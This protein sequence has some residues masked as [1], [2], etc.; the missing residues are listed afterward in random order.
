MTFK[1]QLSA[2]A[3]VVIALTILVAACA[4]DGDDTLRVS[5]GK[6]VFTSVGCAACHGADGE[7]GFGPALAGH[8]EQQVVRQVRAPAGIMPIFPPTVLSDPELAAVVVYVESLE[9]LEP[10]DGDPEADDEADDEAADEAGDAN[11][12]SKNVLSRT[13]VL[14]MHHLMAVGD[15]ES[16]NTV[17]AVDHVEHLIE[18]VEGT[19]QRVMEEVLDLLNSGQVTEAVELIE[20]MIVVNGISEN[21]TPVELHLLV[22]QQ[23][24]VV[25][26]LKTAKI[27]VIHAQ[28]LATDEDLRLILI[29]A[30]QDDVEK[31]E[32]ALLDFLLDAGV[33]D[34]DGGD[35][36][37]VGMG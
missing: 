8:T 9:N 30:D 29:A 16:G 23:S 34:P 33:I 27:H 5:N 31:L 11:D 12:V 10:H 14:Q 26:D 13:Q 25:G 22:A 37:E 35:M 32:E 20:E 21:L 7:G 4:P 3:A 6:A 1:S 2:L 15:A 28:E 18:L 36:V 17:E 19:H 24:A